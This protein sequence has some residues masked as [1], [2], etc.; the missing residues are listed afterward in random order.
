ME[1]SSWFGKTN[2]ATNSPDLTL[3]E[4][5]WKTVKDLLQHHPRLK[6]KE[7][8]AQPIQSTWDTISL[9]Q[10]QSLIRTVPDRMQAVIS[11]RGGSTRWY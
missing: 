8:M 4:N 3:I 5:L 9:E 2:L 1:T 7:K 6:T 11:A 10:L